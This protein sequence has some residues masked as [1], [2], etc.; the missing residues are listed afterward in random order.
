M[1]WRLFRL[2]AS[3]LPVLLSLVLGAGPAP[4]RA[5]L[6]ELRWAT[7]QGASASDFLPARVVALPFSWD[8]VHHG[9]SGEATFDLLVR[10]PTVPTEPYALLFPRLGNRAEVWFNGILLSRFGDPDAVGGDDHAK[11]PHYLLVPAQFLRTDNLLRV[12]IGADAGR[13]GGLA[14]VMFGPDHEVRDQYLRVYRRHVNAPLAVAAFSLLVG[15]VSLAL[16]ATQV[17]SD[18][19]G[20][21]VRPGLYLWAGLSEICWAV[22]LGETAVIAPPLPWPQWGVLQALALAGW[23]SGAALFCHHVAGWQSRSSMRCVRWGAGLLFVSAGPAAVLSLVY[24]FTA[25]QTTW[26]LT[27]LV[28]LL[29]YAT[30]YIAGVWRQ[31]RAETMLVAVAGALNIL[32]GLRDGWVVQAGL[33]FAD[34]S[35]MRYSSLLFGLALL[36]IVVMRFRTASTQ[37]H[38][39]AATLAARVREKE[40]ALAESYREL[41][42]MAREQ[43][44]V[45]ERSRILSDMHDGVGAHISSAIH[46]LR[47]GRV[48]PD[49]L[50]RTLHDSLDHLKLSID[51]MSL[52]PGDLNVLLAGLRYRLEPRL[53]NAGIRLDW[54]VGV[55]PLLDWVDAR[56]LRHLQFMV[57]E[58]VSNVLQHAEATTLCVTLQGMNCGGACLALT[59]NGRGFPP[60]RDP[61]RGLRTLRQRADAI[62]ARLEVQ[63]RPG[64]TRVELTLPAQAS[65][66]PP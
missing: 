24:G 48:A 53:Q 34:T 27:A 20:R 55:V 12:R 23:Y 42:Q 63:S 14:P 1:T 59:D 5:A 39:L 56:V 29:A 50:L 4:A 52:P 17:E 18:P 45:A 7:L 54:Q 25:A 43:E 57:F 35:W 30:V 58:I 21:P 31:R 32:V 9:E 60:E 41:E 10:L 37:A 13:R 6:Q 8:Q 44:R 51:A 47:S 28:L 46:Q 26:D 16:W 3:G 49:E 66:R 64:R 38:D 62:G 15:L 19:D 40:Q 36:C 22:H 61:A 33:Q 11:S 2:L 65:V